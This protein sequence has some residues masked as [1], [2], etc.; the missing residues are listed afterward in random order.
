M[1]LLMKL[2]ATVAA[3]GLAAAQIPPALPFSSFFNS[4]FA[5]TDIET[6]DASLSE[7][8]AS[9][10]NA[11]LNFERSSHAYGGPR[12]DGFYTVPDLTESEIANL[13]PGQILKVQEVAD[14]SQFALSTGSSLS[15]IIYTTQNLNGTIIP[16]S[17]Y[18][19]WPFRPRNDATKAPTVLFAHGTSGIFADSAP[20]AHRLLQYDYHIPFSLVQA[21]YAV[22]APDYAGLGVEKSW[23]GSFI[24]HQYFAAPAGG[25]DMLYAMKAAMEAFER[26]L[27]GKFAVVGHSQGGGVAWSTAEL[28]AAD[29]GKYK[30]DGSDL[31]NITGNSS[32]GKGLKDLVQGYVGTIA[33][34]PVTKPTTM[35]AFTIAMCAMSIDSIFPDFKLSQWLTPLAIS[36]VELL[37]KHQGAATAGQQLLLNDPPEALL[38]PGWQNSSYHARGFSRMV[39]VGDRSFAG[40]ML[41]VQGTNDFFVEEAITN[42]TVSQVCKRDPQSQL[43]LA[44]GEGSGHTPI[45]SELKSTWMDWL[46]AR[47]DGK[48]VN[49]GCSTQRLRGWLG[50]GAHFKGHTSYTQWVGLPEYSYQNLAGI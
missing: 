24:P 35:M 1:V 29:E 50:E 18:I 5:L 28:L 41:V 19:L 26:R 44:I 11:V 22:V 3:T 48:E 17:A 25:Q 20:S 27:S 30:T 49:L 8:S 39:D 46:D 37:R 47:F 34:A 45:I 13:R 2:V 12:Q 36:R 16:A 7:V 42:A 10:F 23:D 14:P 15:R 40:P 4:S 38:Q 21:G 9:S 32:E 33:M 6:Q 31:P 43:Q